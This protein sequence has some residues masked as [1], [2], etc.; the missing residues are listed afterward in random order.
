MKKRFTKGVTLIELVIVMV[1]VG[2]TAT[3]IGPMLINA[4]RSANMAS[5]L[6]NLSGQ[7]Q[8]ATTRIFE[9][10][11]NLETI[12]VESATSIT[13]T[14]TNGDVIIYT[15]SSGFLTRSVNGTVGKLAKGVSGFD[16]DYFNSAGAL[17]TTLADIRY[18][19]PQFT[20]TENGHSDNFRTTVFLRNT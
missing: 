10:L 4:T 16:L 11:H 13:F 12:N 3:V 20:I 17:T 14:K 8:Y 18:V 9:D 1:I 5:D 7:G 6:N 2:I 15:T 19:R